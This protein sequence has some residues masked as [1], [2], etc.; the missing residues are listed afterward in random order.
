MWPG[1]LY[2]IVGFETAAAAGAGLPDRVRVARRGRAE[3]RMMVST[4]VCP[5]CAS[6]HSGDE[7]FCARCGMPLVHGGPAEAE[8]SERQQRARKI[9]PEYAQGPLVRVHQR[10][11][12]ARGRARRGDAARGGDPEPAAP[13]ARLRRSR[14][15]GVGPARR[16]RAAVRARRRAR[17]PARRRGRTAAHPARARAHARGAP[18]A[19]RRSSR[20]PLLAIVLFMATH[21]WD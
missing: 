16:A 13:L 11:Q 9:R 7:R 12:P 2:I 4:L 6:E 5:Q 14:L 15:H 8:R 1:T 19:R 17:P 10:P 3:R 20:S 21:V 18:R